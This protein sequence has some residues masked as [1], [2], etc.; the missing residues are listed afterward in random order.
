MKRRATFLTL[1]LMII[2]I[3]I[4]GCSREQKRREEVPLTSEEVKRLLMNKEVRIGMEA[5]QVS[6][7]CGKPKK[8]NESVSARTK[9]EQWVYGS[10]IYLYFENG[11]LTSYHLSR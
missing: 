3:P 7:L 6:R 4:L 5:E 1:I 2:L 11:V 9:R 8:I 10:G